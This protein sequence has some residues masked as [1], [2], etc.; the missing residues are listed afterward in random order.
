ML[1]VP[2]ARA[3]D[4]PAIDATRGVETIQRLLSE[5]QFTEARKL[6]ERLLQAHPDLPAVQLEA[7]WVKFH[8][9]EHQAAL[10]L[11]DR[12]SA[13]FGGRMDRNVRLSLI[14]ATARVTR[15]FEREQSPNGKVI[16]FRRPGP[17]EILTPYLFETLG[18]T[19]EVAGKD[20]GHELDHPVLVEIVPD[21]A[22]LADMTG[23]TA[24]E[25][26]TSGTIAVCK[27]GRLM[28]TTPRATLKGFGWL[29]T[30]SH[31]L[32]HMIISEK[33]RNRVPIWL[34]EALAKYEDS[35][36]RSSEPL[37]RPGLHPVR[38]SNLAR[39]LQSGSLITFEQMHPSMALLPS[40][41]AAELAFSEVYTVTRFLLDR[42][43]YE[44]IR[45][46]L[47]H[48]EKGLSDM[49]AIQ[50]VYGLDRK[51]FVSAWLKWLTNQKL[52]VLTGDHTIHSRKPVLTGR[53]NQEERTLG[54]QKVTDL[55]DFY[56]L[57]QLLR[58]RG[59]TRAS[60][61]EYQKA[62]DR[63]GPTHVALW[64]LSDKL[65][66]ALLAIDRDKEARQ[67]F[68][69][70][71][72]VNPLDLEA[73]L[74]LARLELDKDP[75]RSFLHLRECM[76]INPLD[77]RIHRLSFQAATRLA[78]QGDKR[79]DWKR[80]RKR[81]QHAMHILQR[82]LP[83]RKTEQPADAKPE[84]ESQEAYLTGIPA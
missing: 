62:V 77:P 38:E 44:G 8:L 47:G 28:I 10:E 23:L 53:S 4:S 2:A 41:E 36:W 25:I 55:R 65:G 68:Q 43:G 70:A 11:L 71:L 31:E 76:R 78:K 83:K 73:H 60:V 72:K 52:K 6:S 12:A 79:E 27:Y 1:L 22:A 67:A 84:E 49:E 59:R 18:R 40:P 75:Y 34:H 37:F 14:R 26:R 9:A 45:A 17:D 56:H 35:R 21:E 80:H 29:D 39:A 69:A 61:V 13:A 63:A 58:A 46:L 66:L 7:A 57:G 16:I 19:L 3:Q 20:L 15:D 24:E 33:T 48:I 32:I 64:L 5:W 51:A 54:R 42:K 74:H 81:H 30:A 82:H 50:E